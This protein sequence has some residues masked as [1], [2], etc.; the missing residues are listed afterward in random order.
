MA[1]S[2]RI[3][4]SDEDRTRFFR[5]SLVIIEELTQILRDLLSNEVPPM[6]IYTKVKQSNY[7]QN[8]RPEQI[9]VIRNATTHGYHDFDI[10]LLYTLLRNVCQTILP[11]S[12]SWGV[13]NMPSPVKEI[14]V[15]DDIERIRLIR[16]EVYGHISEA[17]MTETKFKDYWTTISGICTRMQNL[18]NK[19]YPKRLQEA[20]ECTIDADTEKKYIELIKRLAN[21]DK[22]IKDIIENKFQGNFFYLEPIDTIKKYPLFCQ[23]V[24]FYKLNYN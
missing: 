14:T 3:S 19:D 20:K 4:G 16:N 10:T 23:I 8:L 15:G 22:T 6:K 7:F 13:S 9:I 17:A 11:P 1:S 2:V 24:M 18:L 5:V 21:E 12:K